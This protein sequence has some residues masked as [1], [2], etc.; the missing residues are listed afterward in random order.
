MQSCSGNDLLN[1]IM[2]YRRV[3]FDGRMGVNNHTLVT[4]Y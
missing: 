2:K 1:D 4:K 3:L